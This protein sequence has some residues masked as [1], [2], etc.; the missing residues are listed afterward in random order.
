MQGPTRIDARTGEAK[1]FGIRN[2]HR[3]MNGEIIG[4]VTAG[5]Q[6][7]GTKVREM[8][9]QLS[10]SATAAPQSAT[11]RL[12]AGPQ[13]PGLDSN[14]AQ[15][16]NLD[17]RKSLFREMQVA[18]SG[19]ITP[20]MKQRA[21]SLGVKR[22]GWDSATSK[23]TAAPAAVA[24]PGATPAPVA[25]FR[26]PMAPPAAPGAPAAP[27]D[28]KTRVA[29][30]WKRS[31]ADKAR[32]AEKKRAGMAQKGFRDAAGPLAAAKVSGTAPIP[33]NTPS[34]EK[35]AGLSPSFRPR[36]RWHGNFA[37]TP[38]NEFQ[39]ISTPPPAPS[40][41]GPPAPK[42][43]SEFQALT[44]GRSPAPAQSQSAPAK[45]SGAA[46]IKKTA[47]QPNVGSDGFVSLGAP[48]KDASQRFK[49]EEK[50]G[51]KAPL[52]SAALAAGTGIRRLG[53]DIA[54]SYR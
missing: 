13:T 5:G 14:P 17:K 6:R 46:K 32:D 52:R 35:T 50:K 43:P 49:A 7:F 8:A 34:F 11:P 23:L 40:L 38:A 44:G 31:A 25:G 33:K 3:G 18:G 21:A 12:D 48:F 29:D 28:L 26:A 15:P 24:A 9:P 27:Q 53:S 39:A 41:A 36:R 1:E 47:T 19:G 54:K 20:E 10:A 42:P 22:G 45:P 2:T 51:Y 4:G 16:T 30:Y 37:V